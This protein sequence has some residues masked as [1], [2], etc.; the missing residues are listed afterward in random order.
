MFHAITVGSALGS[1]WLSKR[2]MHTASQMLP[3]SEDD[4]FSSYE[5]DVRYE[6]LD[7]LR[8]S[9]L[10]GDCPTITWKYYA[11][12]TENE[13]TVLTR[14]DFVD[15]VRTIAQL[16]DSFAV[17][18]CHEV[19]LHMSVAGFPPSIEE[20]RVVIGLCR[21]ARNWKEAERVVV[22]MYRQ[23]LL[24]NGRIYEDLMSM[25]G[26]LGEVD[27]ATRLYEEML[28]LGHQPTL[29]GVPAIIKACGKTGDIEQ[30]EAMLK[31]LNSLGLQ[32]SVD[33]YA[34]LIH[35]YAKAGRRAIAMEY[36]D[37]MISIGLQ[38]NV[39]VYTIL[40]DA[41]YRAGDQLT[42]RHL[43]KLMNLAG[44]EPDV[45]LYGTLIA[46]AA[47]M[48]DF[49]EVVI[50]FNQLTQRAIQPNDITYDG[51]L[52]G[53]AHHVEPEAIGR[54]V[55]AMRRA[56]AE[57]GVR[58]LNSLLIA[59]GK[60]GYIDRA[61]TLLMAWK[62]SGRDVNTVNYNTLLK[63]YAKVL[64][65]SRALELMEGLI[66]TGFK[67]NVRTFNILLNISLRSGDHTSSDKVLTAM[68][69]RH[70]GADTVTYNTVMSSVTMSSSL[71][72][73][74]EEAR[75]RKIKLDRVSFH[76]ILRNF[77]RERNATGAM[78]VFRLMRSMGIRPDLKAWTALIDAHG[79]AGDLSRM[80][81]L[82]NILQ[83]E[84]W[85][86]DTVLYTC[87]VDAYGRCNDV[88]GAE[89]AWTRMITSGCKP[90]SKAYAQLLKGYVR[91]RNYGAA[92]QVIKD[93]QLRGVTID[94]VIYTQLIQCAGIARGYEFGRTIFD[95]MIASG[96][97]PDI[98]IF[99]ILLAVGS[100]GARVEDMTALLG[101]MWSRAIQPNCFSYRAL[102]RGFVA[103]MGAPGI[104][105]LHALLTAA[106]GFTPD[107]AY[108]QE[109]LRAHSMCRDADGM[110]AT[111][112]NMI[113]CGIR[114]TASLL[115]AF[116]SGT[117]KCGLH[118]T[119]V[120]IWKAY[121]DLQEHMASHPRKGGSV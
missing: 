107:E 19:L 115:S 97:E 44:I 120:Q 31:R 42:V 14:E 73:I 35:L 46:G 91:A 75:R 45:V 93:M 56:G 81:E 8:N 22:K 6:M 103:S 29:V 30:A 34:A 71:G 12:L 2:K 109:R 36:F 106:E 65:V 63:I 116:V 104:V 119:A 1:L 57:P 38:P 60:K 87:L 9:L 66:L 7:T 98:H 43:Q 51:F 83:E 50:L 76:I 41:Y 89:G 62:K 11:A 20:Y 90:S 68:R 96:A 95:E 121:P 85:T 70:I 25:Y 112:S 86:P 33:I 117:G 23:G 118:D 111:W 21:R 84:G 3:V 77:A 55:D 114:P 58:A 101:E 108:Y 10:C 94:R 15:I 67:P 92:W 28:R 54:S 88:A 72:P 105:R 80:E 32:P 79:K 102:F 40:I 52:A 113:Q 69:E 18:R 74:V 61:S 37:R 99:N 39:A 27:K 47:R 49:E 17:E 4:Q 13:R 59:L 5:P 53:C 100:R 48:G 26:E 82:M 64:G 16:P 24:I 110:A 78:N